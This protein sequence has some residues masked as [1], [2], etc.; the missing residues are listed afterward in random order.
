MHNCIWFAESSSN[1][2]W[3][4]TE[5]VFGGKYSISD[6]SSYVFMIF[7]IRVL[8]C[9][10]SIH[11]TVVRNMQ[12]SLRVFIIF[13]STHGLGTWCLNGIVPPLNHW[14]MLHWVFVLYLSLDL[15]PVEV[16]YASIALLL[17]WAY[18]KEFMVIIWLVCSTFIIQL[19]CSMFMVWFL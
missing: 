19:V 6:N 10:L 15:L 11:F 1:F 17:M 2:G 7:K 9:F 14:C 5:W 4:D 13:F 16:Y 3:S 12:L 18:V 8:T